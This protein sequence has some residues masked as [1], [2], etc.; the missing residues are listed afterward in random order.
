VSCEWS[1]STFEARISEQP[2]PPGGL[3]MGPNTQGACAHRINPWPHWVDMLLERLGTRGKLIVVQP[4]QLVL[5]WH[6]PGTAWHT[7][8]F[9]VGFRFARAADERRLCQRGGFA[10][11]GR[12]VIKCTTSQTR[13][14]GNVI[15]Q[16]ARLAA[17]I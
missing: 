11:K 12:V 7:A 9:D 17:L 10:G 16:L 5:P 1:S 14:A 8:A 13:P 6:N 15:F 2:R 3:G 4:I